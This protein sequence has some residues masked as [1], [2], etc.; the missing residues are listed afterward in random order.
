M[1][2]ALEAQIRKAIAAAA[3]LTGKRFGLLVAS[4]VVATSVIVAAAMTSANGSG[5][6]A[7]LLGRSLAADRTP[8]IEEP[9]AEEEAFEPEEE[10]EA[11]PEEFAPEATSSSEEF[12][13]EEEAPQE[14]AAPV[15]EE[16]SEV[17]EIPL[18]EAG[19]IKHVFV[20]S[21]ASPGYEAS[22]GATTQ[23]PYLASTLRP[24]G[25]LLSGYTLL[26]E[27]SLPNEIAA[28]SGQT[29]NASTEADCATYSEFP[30]SASTDKKGVVAG[31]GCVY[32]VTTLTLAD[33]LGAGRFTWHAYLEGMADETGK[34]ANCVHPE[35]EA[36]ET[37]VTGGYSARLNPFVY[38]H[39]LL[40]LG[41]CS[42][43]DVPGTE[44]EK[45]LKKTTTTPSFSYISPNLCNAGFTGQCPEGGPAG[46]AATDAWLATVVPKILAS[47]AYKAD[48][49][50]IVS[51]GSVAQPAPVEAGV[52]PAP[53][54]TEPLKTG[55]LLVTKFATPGATDAVKYNPYSLLRS[56][57]ELFG[58][59]H[60]GAA[61]G[62]AVK[63]FAPA[64]LGENGGD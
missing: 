35:S 63:T 14:E 25:V 59:N 49:L 21:L 27:A 22:F 48:G 3:T 57:E 37:A 2:R 5:P 29:P 38:F 23:M 12:A 39:S 7:S 19:R 31:S 13:P 40:D 18:P 41:D 50:L 11:A 52:T 6:L 26:D 55:A 42:T 16:E 1:R 64:L 51:F 62:N 44:L 28:V 10:A 46:A 43:N 56:S 45:D 24:K 36:A 58:L 15:E 4:S 34:P 53:A 32:P 54:P 8:A 47:A 61:Q 20:V 33:Q 30:P 9:V 60:I 17:P